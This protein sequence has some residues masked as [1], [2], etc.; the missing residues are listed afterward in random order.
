[1]GGVRFA[2]GQPPL[3]RTVGNPPVK[4]RRHPTLRDGAQA[5]ALICKQ[6]DRQSD[7]VCNFLRICMDTRISFCNLCVGA[8]NR[9][10]IPR[11]WFFNWGR[12]DGSGL[13]TC[14]FRAKANQIV[15]YIVVDPY[16]VP[17]VPVHFRH[18]IL[19]VHGTEF[20]HYRYMFPSIFLPCCTPLGIVRYTFKFFIIIFPWTQFN[21]R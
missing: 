9:L 7:I 17:M 20:N 5:D 6:T 11:K 21:Y 15:W 16:L 19:Y 10:F 13:K 3:Q 8:W 2:A 1:M 18:D 14:Q 12:L 4:V